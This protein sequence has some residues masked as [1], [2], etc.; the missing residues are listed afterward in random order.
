[1]DDEQIRQKQDRVDQFFLSMA[2][3]V[4]AKHGGT[5]DIDAETRTVNFDVPKEH[6]VACALE[7]EQLFKEY[8][9]NED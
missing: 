9:A 7:I 5:V 2:V 1:M 8:A 4:A 6:E 3:V